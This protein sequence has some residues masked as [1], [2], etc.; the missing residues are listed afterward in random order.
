MGG[1]A[2]AHIYLQEQIFRKEKRRECEA[3]FY[4]ATYLF[5]YL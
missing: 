2:L 4:L 1:Q 5:I 3:H